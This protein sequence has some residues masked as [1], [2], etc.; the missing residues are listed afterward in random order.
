MRI[1]DILATANSNLGKAKLRTFLTIFA[2]FIGATTLTLTNSVGIGVRQYIDKQLAGA[3]SENT[4][5]ISKEGNDAPDN[6]LREYDPSRQG[7]SVNVFSKSE[8]EQVKNIEH[9][10]SI[11][12]SPNVTIEYFEINGKKY[13]GN[14]NSYPRGV[15]VDL[16]AGKGLDEEGAGDVILPNY[17]IPAFGESANDAPGKTITI[18]VRNSV[19]GTIATFPVT[20]SGISNKNLISGTF[21][22]GNSDLVAKM[23]EAQNKGIANAEVVYG[24]TAELE[25]GL[26]SAQI[27]TIKDELVKIR[28]KGQTFEDQYQTVSSVIK[29]IQLG[30]NVF[31]GIALAA[32]S[33]GIINTLLMAINERTR[34]IGLMKA[35]GMSRGKIFSLFSFEAILIGIWGSAFGV[36]VALVVGHFGNKYLATLKFFQNFEGLTLSVFTVP[37][38]LSIVGLIVVIAFIAGA[39]PSWRAARQ[40]PIVALRYE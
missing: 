23:A 28:A 29:G 27:Q 40:D 11:D 31:G 35:L 12:T 18:A 32:A 38:V 13:A 33:F 10:K 14:I 9:I 7:A 21:T 1:L 17:Y 16:A 15:R 19:N 26:T 6:T 39:L 30:L 20:V 2:V 36:A 3:G 37:S 24:L 22:I 5:F 25:S 34:E 4:L 8:V